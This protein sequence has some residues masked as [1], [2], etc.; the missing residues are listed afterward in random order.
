MNAPTQPNL[1]WSGRPAFRSVVGRVWRI[2]WAAAYFA[3]LAADGAVGL[4]RDPGAS[5]GWA[6]EAKLIA[7]G[8][9]TVA[10][11]TLFAW[12]TRRTTLYEITSRAVTLRYG[13]ALQRTLAIPFAAIAEVKL[14][15]NRDGAGD[16]ALRLKEGQSVSY[17]KLWP[18][19]LDLSLWRPEPMLISIVEP[20]VVG[21][22]LC[23]AMAADALARRAYQDDA[24]RQRLAMDRLEEPLA[25]TP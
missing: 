17:L 5:A 15:V 22:L 25:A 20:G 23:R 3:L 16:L 13:I 6:G 21:A 8:A 24:A 2:R 10:L 19:V 4:W 1:L 18:H 12:L 9:A 14:R 11:L 7:M